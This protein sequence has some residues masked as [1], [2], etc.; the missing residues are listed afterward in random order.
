MRECGP[1]TTSTFGPWCTLAGDRQDL[2]GLPPGGTFLELAL[3]DVALAGVANHGGGADAGAV[4]GGRRCGTHRWSPDRV[5]AHGRASPC[6]TPVELAVP[7]A[8][9]RWRWLATPGSSNVTLSPGPRDEHG[10]RSSPDVG[11]SRCR[12]VQFVRV[13]RKWSALSRTKWPSSQRRT[14][15]SNAC[16]RTMSPIT[17]V[18]VATRHTPT[19][20]SGTRARRFGWRIW[21]RANTRSNSPPADGGRTPTL[22]MGAPPRAS[23][24]IGPRSSGSRK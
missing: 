16:G 4:G 19:D 21:S 12:L 23:R 6:D 17:T 7:E 18:G 9:G 2:L 24:G 22:V 1:S 3:A 13:P 8:S 14:R 20:G 11:G 5:V 10:A 15:C